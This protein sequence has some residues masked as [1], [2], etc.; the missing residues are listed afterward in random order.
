MPIP[1]GILAQYIPASAGSYELIQS[2]VLGSNSSSVSFTNLGTYASTYQ[3]LQL[4]IVTRNTSNV[5][6]GALLMTL[7]GDTAQNY[8]FHELRG[9]GSSVTSSAVVPYGYILPSWNPHGGTNPSN[10]GVAVADILDWS[11]TSKFKTVRSLTGVLSYANFISMF[12]GVWR[13]TAAIT[14]ITFTAEAGN[15]FVAGSRYSLYGIK[16][17]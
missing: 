5:G 6:T 11:S 9:N 8:T 14:S 2:T 10:F 13:S 15:Q 17:S 12:S 3:H 7:N 4:R 1:L 16:G